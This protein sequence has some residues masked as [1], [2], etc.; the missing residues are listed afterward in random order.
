[1]TVGY[2]GT[3]LPQKLG[4]KEDMTVG[5]VGAPKGF[6]ALLSELPSGVILHQDIKPSSMFLVFAQWADEASDR[7]GQ[8]V[9]SLPAEGSIWMAWPKKGSGLETDIDENTLR[10]LF[11]STGMVDNKVCAIDE[12]WS[13][14]R[15]VVR[16]ENRPDWNRP[17]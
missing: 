15:F 4:I 7:F 6:Y 11:L 2:S 3:P 13:G 9:P 14:L 12:T 8:V 10:D 16:K 17:A 1:M 5:V